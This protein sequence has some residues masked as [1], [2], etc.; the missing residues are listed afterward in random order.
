MPTANTGGGGGGGDIHSI[1]IPIDRDSSGSEAETETPLLSGSE[2]PTSTRKHKLLTESDVQ[3]MVDAGRKVVIKDGLVLSLDKWFGRHPG[4]EMVILHMVGRDA[5]DE[6]NAYHCA[7]TL[8]RM[9][10]F[11]IGRIDSS[12]PWTNIMPPIQ[13]TV[14][15]DVQTILDAKRI[16]AEEDIIKALELAAK[17][18]SQQ[19]Q[20]SGSPER[21]TEYDGNSLTTCSKK[22]GNSACRARVSTPAFIEMAEK[23]EIEIDLAKNPSLD[24]TTQQYIVSR[25]RVLHDKVKEAHLYD[26]NYVNYLKELCRYSLLFACF[27][28]ALKYEY[29]LVSAAFLGMFWHQIMFTAHDAGH[30]A[31]T[32]NFVVDSLIGIFIADFCCGLSLG[33]WKS[34]HNVHHLVTNH[35]EHDPDIQNAPLLATSPSFFR[36]IK[37]TYYGGF[38][39]FWDKTADYIAPLQKYTYYPIMGIARFNLYLLSWI[40]LLRRNNSSLGKARWTRPTEMLFMACY[41]YLFGYRLLWLSIPTWGMRVAFVLVSHVI[42]FPLH[43][44]ITLSHFSMSTADLG[45]SESFAQR[46][47]RTTMDVDCPEWFDWVHGGLQFQAIHH[48]FPRVPRHNLRKVQKLVKAFCDETGLEYKILGFVEG[49][50]DV[51]SRLGEVGRQVEFLRKCEGWVRENKVLAEAY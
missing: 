4:G 34:S 15:P 1:T 31:I 3:A 10:G 40:H 46:Q 13:Q 14:G 27:F 21:E 35:P 25:Y 32:H 16:Q 41:W 51:L 5:T 26:C 23:H 17:L 36:S 8:S 6:I 19:Q 50:K 7:D 30:L 43:I 42:T 44:Q 28:T 38:V 18:Q 12:K 39:F 45:P 47:L 24:Q 48:L 49:N 37:S 33:W 29:F 9:S 22:Y 20:V 2:K 11:A